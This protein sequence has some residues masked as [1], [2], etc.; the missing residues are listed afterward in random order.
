[1]FSRRQETEGWEVLLGEQLEGGQQKWQEKRTLK[2]IELHGLYIDMMEGYDI[3]VVTLAQPVV[4][5]DSISAICAPYAAHQFP[6]GSTCWTRGRRIGTLW[7]SRIGR[8]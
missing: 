4:F 6:F 1:M 7:I 5:N 8:E 2:N 3:A